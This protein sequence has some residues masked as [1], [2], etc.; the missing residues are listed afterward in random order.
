MP[1]RR[2]TR[3]D[4]QSNWFRERARQRARERERESE[5]QKEREK[6]E[7][8]RKEREREKE[9]RSTLYRSHIP[10]KAAGA[11]QEALFVTTLGPCF[12]RVLLD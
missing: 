9:Y 2:N 10:K 8:E 1:K 4:P 7:R 3:K 6:R 5:K 11:Q 12:A